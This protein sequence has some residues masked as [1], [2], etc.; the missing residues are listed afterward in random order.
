[1]RWKWILGIA[2]AVLVAIFITVIIIVSSY[3]YNNLKP[4]ITKSVSDSTGREL[5]IAGD[6]ELKIGFVP[7]LVVQDVD[8]QNA[9]WGSR[10]QMIEIKH[11]EVELALIPLIRGNI[12]VRRLELIEPDILIEINKSGASNLEFKAPQT[13]Q[14]QS[15][16]RS[17]QLPEIALKELEIHKAKLA[18][19][20]HQSGSVRTFEMDLLTMKAPAF[21]EPADIVLKGA[22]NRIPYRVE[23]KLGPLANL[24]DPAKPWPVELKTRAMDID[25]SLKG[26]ITDVMNLAGVDIDLKIDGKDF[27]SF[28]QITAAPL[29]VK[30]PFAVAGHVEASSLERVSISDFSATLN[31]SQVTGSIAF[32]LIA[33]RPR[34]KAT[35][36]A[37]KLDLRPLIADAPTSENAGVQPAKMAENSGKVFSGTPLELDVLRQFDAVIQLRITQ[38]FLPKLALENLDTK[39]NLENGHLKVQPL[40]ALIG[41]GRFAGNLDLNARPNVPTLAAGLKIEGFDLGN[42]LDDMSITEAADGKINISIKANSRGNS[43]AA[44][45]GALNGHVKILMSEGQIHMRYIN[46]IGADMRAGLGRLFNPLKEKQQYAQVNCFVC[47]F[48]IRDGLADSDVFL[49]DTNRMTVAAN[50]SVNLKTEKLNFGVQPKPKE[51]LGTQTTGKVSISLS[52]FAK[53]FRLGGTLANPQLAIDTTQTA[54]TLGKS[55]GGMVLLGPVGIASA[56]IS[57]GSGET[58]PCM[59]AIENLKAKES[60]AKETG[61]PEKKST[62]EKKSNGIGSKIKRLFSKPQN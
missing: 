4:I 28:E 22:Y 46:L 44:L 23:G 33:K 25:V 57:T 1:M 47:R 53:P 8:F 39:L 59:T 56:L 48:N 36:S 42:M 54:L 15:A 5:N 62:S 61:K 7:S 58:H 55:I 20:D 60:V 13:S 40:R 2:A 26:T 11:F 10:P 12:K 3:D 34:I 45:M 35:L 19:K 43:V 14:K 51:G 18:I 16:Q 41:D 24:L 50:G 49:V 37:K 9:S 6:I 52:E 27:A 32:D 17:S 38:L 31:K 21:G 30:G 29:P